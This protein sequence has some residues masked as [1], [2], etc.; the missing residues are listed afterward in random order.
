MTTTITPTATFIAN[1]VSVD[2]ETNERHLTEIKSDFATGVNTFPALAVTTLTKG[3]EVVIT[4][5]PQKDFYSIDVVVPFTEDG[6]IY[7]HGLINILSGSHDEVMT[8]LNEAIEEPYEIDSAVK[9]VLWV[10]FETAA[11]EIAQHVQE[12]PVNV[13]D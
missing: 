7:D 13:E 3:H 12:N 9:P 8:I 1:L 2:A 4:H 10:A 11:A 6:V 5:T